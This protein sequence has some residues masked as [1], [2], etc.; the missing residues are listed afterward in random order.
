MLSKMFAK[1]TVIFMLILI[2]FC[3]FVFKYSILFGQP[4]YADMSMVIQ[5]CFHW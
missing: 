5:G 4:V 2:C 1:L 3:G